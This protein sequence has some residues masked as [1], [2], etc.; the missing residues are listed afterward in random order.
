MVTAAAGD[1][2]LVEEGAEVVGVDA[3]DVEG[4]EGGAAAR[5]RA[6]IGHL[7]EGG[8]LLVEVSANLDLVVVNAVHANVGEVIVSL[9]RGRWPRRWPVC[10]LR[11]FRAVLARALFRETRRRSSRRRG[12]STGAS[13]ARRRCRL[14]GNRYQSVR[15][16]C[17]RCRRSS[18]LSGL[19]RPPSC[20][21]SF[22]IV[23]KHLGPGAAR[24]LDDFR[25]R[26]LSTGDVTH[27][28]RR[29][30]LGLSF[31]NDRS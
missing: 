26:S 18:P 29:D 24:E 19:G 28:R 23:E 9:R 17:A 2:G 4:A 25:H 31:T 3:V 7:G 27:V 8:E 13:S 11:I 30:E 12:L 5:G 22:G 10:R 16:F 15:T 21:A 6:V 20:G 14:K 1:A